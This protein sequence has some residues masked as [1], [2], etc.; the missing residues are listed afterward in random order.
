MSN[1]RPGPHFTWHELAMRSDAV[2]REK[3][4][5]ANPPL[6]LRHALTALVVS[7]LEPLR[8]HT[9]PIKITSGWRSQK[10]NKR[11]GGSATSQH[12]FGEAVDILVHDDGGSLMPAV[13]VLRLIQSLQLPIDQAIGYHISRGGHVHV[14]HSVS[15]AN[16]RQYLWVGE[17]G[18]YTT[19]RGDR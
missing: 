16:R 4:T 5:G 8:A 2:A 15:R 10:H 13:D 7:V 19:W 9:G 11:I 3:Y 1:D 6:S 12:M 18:A 17:D 14:S